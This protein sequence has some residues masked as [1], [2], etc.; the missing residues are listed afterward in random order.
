MFNNTIKTFTLLAGLAGLAIAVG[1]LLGGS[2]GL[3]IGLLSR[4][5]G[6][7]WATMG[8]SIARTFLCS[9]IFFCF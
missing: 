4:S 1:G 7:C 8:T 6:P 9:D 5:R 3:V 2:T